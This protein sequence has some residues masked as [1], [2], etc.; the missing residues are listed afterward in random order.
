MF[1]AMAFTSLPSQRLILG[2]FVYLLEEYIIKP[3]TD[4]GNLSYSETKFNLSIS[5]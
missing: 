1:K 3:C 5:K 2:D 4:R